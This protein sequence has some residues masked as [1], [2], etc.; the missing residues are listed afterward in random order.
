MLTLTMKILFNTLSIISVL[1]AYFVNICHAFT[2]PT[3]IYACEKIVV[4]VE[5]ERRH[6]LTHDVNGKA[7]NIILKD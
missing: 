2:S 6:C 4:S 3:A 7:Y 5:D 1:T